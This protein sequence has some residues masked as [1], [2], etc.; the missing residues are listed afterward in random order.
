MEKNLRILFINVKYSSKDLS[1][2]WFEDGD[3]NVSYNC[4]DRH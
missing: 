2:K 4:I 1:I 3:L